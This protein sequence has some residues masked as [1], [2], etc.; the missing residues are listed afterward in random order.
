MRLL[1]IKDAP[2][3][4]PPDDKVLAIHLTVKE[5]IGTYIDKVSDNRVTL[6]QGVTLRYAKESGWK[7][8]RTEACP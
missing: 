3:E 6:Y 5:K 8:T 7:H 2:D 1:D 4:M